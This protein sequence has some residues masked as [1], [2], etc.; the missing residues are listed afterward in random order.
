LLKAVGKITGK[1]QVQVPKVIRDACGLKVGDELV[2][3]LDPNRLLVVHIRKRQKLLDLAGILE[4]RHNFPGIEEE[5]EEEE[6][7]TRRVIAEKIAHKG[8]KNES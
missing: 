6:E 4:P 7:G 2:F 8:L 5:E 3:Q 1:G